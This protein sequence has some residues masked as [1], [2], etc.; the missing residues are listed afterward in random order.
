MWPSANCSCA[1]PSRPDHPS[2]GQLPHTQGVVMAARVPVTAADT[3]VRVCLLLATA[4]ALGDGLQLPAQGGPADADSVHRFMAGVHV[5]WAPLFFWTAATI[6]RQ[7][8]LVHFLAVPIFLGGVGRLVSFAQNGTER[9]LAVE[10][11]S[12]GLNFG[13]PMRHLA[14]TL[15]SGGVGESGMGHYHGRYSI[16]TFSHREAV[17]DGP[18]S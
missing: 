15:P 7:G 18:L 14:A 12:G 1:P 8:V 13:L 9:R 17:L 6:H 4:M 2:R 5:G 3:V 16:E 10:T 11:S